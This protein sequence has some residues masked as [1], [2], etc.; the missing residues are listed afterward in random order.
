MR[1]NSRSE[2][3]AVS[4]EY[5]GVGVAL[6]VL[7][8]ALALSGVGGSISKSFGYVFCT[9]ASVV[10]GRSCEKPASE[11]TDTRT[12]KEIAESGDYV[13]LGD[14]YSSGEGAD[15]YVDNTN[16]DDHTKQAIN[17]WPVDLWPGDP[18]NNI[19]RR[20]ANA[21]S[22]TVYDQGDFQG[23]YVFGACSGGITDDY[24]EDNQGGNEGEGPQRDH[25]TEDTSLITISMGG[26]DFGFGD[27]VAGCVISGSTYGGAGACGDDASDDVKAAID[28]KVDDLIKLYQDL[29]ADS[30]DDARIL[31]VGYPQLFPDNPSGLPLAITNNDQKWLNEMGDYAN[32][33]IQRA[34]RESGT[35]VEFVDVTRALEGHEV[36]TDESWIHDLKAGIDGGW[37]KP[38]V[39]NNSF[40]PTSE[41]QNAIAA[42][43]QQQVE[44]GP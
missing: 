8:T 5:V 41:G 10:D 28:D 33:A 42:I 6:I 24:Y 19:C 12:P 22:A 34:I 23:D 44:E 9:A 32:L 39:S 7:V 26:N 25:I 13:A 20:S 35:N 1:S 2:H 17:D 31:I 37:L 11:T 21:Y 29:E 27:T 15:D 38:P 4:V 43:V 40:H 3:G 36:G 18:H 30:P 16:S 14:S